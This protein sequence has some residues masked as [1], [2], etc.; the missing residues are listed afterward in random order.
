MSKL[1]KKEFFSVLIAGFGILSINVQAKEVI[2]PVND[3]QETV[4]V[5]ITDTRLANPDRI[6]VNKLKNALQ[7][8]G[9]VKRKR[10]NNQRIRG[11]VDIELLSA[12]G[13][14]IESKLI[15]LKT[16][17]GS[18]KHDHMRRFSAMFTLPDSSD[19]QVAVKHHLYRKGH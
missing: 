2:V 14:V 6:Q 9:V 7:V 10:H 5:E 19:Y 12:S 13:K 17:A 18:A 16:K 15:E 8:M 4:K 1:H 11:H 3:L